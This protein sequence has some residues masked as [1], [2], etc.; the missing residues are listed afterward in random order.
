M[1]KAHTEKKKNYYLEGM[2]V[3]LVN[4][5][6]VENYHSRYDEYK[7]AY[8]TRKA[9]IE[10]LFKEIKIIKKIKSLKQKRLKILFCFLFSDYSPKLT[11]SALLTLSIIFSSSI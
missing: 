7:K 9:I 11:P 3:L 5:E 4:N 8:D 10:N 1:N 2:K 6:T